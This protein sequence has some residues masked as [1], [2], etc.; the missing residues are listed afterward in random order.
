MKFS[1][2][3]FC[4]IMLYSTQTQAQPADQPPKRCGKYDEMVTHLYKIGEKLFV[5]GELDPATGL[6]ARIEIWS[7][8]DG[9][10]WTLIAVDP[11][12]IKAC[13]IVIGDQL[14]IKPLGHET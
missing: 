11:E 10:G 4:M 3:V 6:R 13:M 8:H 9:S 12:S 1:I 5:S 7:T 14:K 2:A